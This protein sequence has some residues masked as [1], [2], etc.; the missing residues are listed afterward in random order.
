MIRRSTTITK[1]QMYRQQFS[2]VYFHS[3]IPA[4][5]P[6]TNN[7]FLVQ[8]M[9]TDGKRQEALLEYFKAPH[10]VTAAF[11]IHRLESLHTAVDVYR[12]AKV[13]NCSNLYIVVQLMLQYKQQKQNHNLIDDAV[14]EFNDCVAN[15]SNITAFTINGLLDEL[16][17]V[18]RIHEVLLVFR[19]AI[20]RNLHI[21]DYIVSVLLQCCKRI[22]RFD[23]SLEIWNSMNDTF[24]FRPNRFCYSEMI[25][26]YCALNNLEKAV[27]ILRD[28]RKNSIEATDF[29]FRYLIR[30]CAKTNQR[31]LL[32]QVVECLDASL[33]ETQQKVHSD[34]YCRN[35]LVNMYGDSEELD[36]AVCIFDTIPVEQRN[37][38]TWTT[39]MKGYI[40]NNDLS[41]AV[42][43]LDTMRNAGTKPNVVTYT[44]L[45]SGCVEASAL[46]I[47]VD[48]H[49]R[50]IQEGI[51]QNI[52][53]MSTLVNM[54]GSCGD[55]DEAIRVFDTIPFDHRNVVSWTSMIK[56][57]IS[58]NNF[59]AAVDLLDVMT[60]AGINPDAVTFAT[61]L[62][63][64]VEASS[65]SIGVKLHKKL[66]QED[67]EQD[68]VLMNALVN[69]YGNCGDI[70]EAVRVFDAISFE[71]RDAITWTFMIKAYLNNGNPN[72]AI[73]LLD[74]MM[75]AGVK[76]NIVT[77]ITL[78]TGCAD[79][80]MPDTG[81]ML[82]KRIVQED[83]H[84]NINLKGAL[85]NM[86]GK[87]SRIEDAEFAFSSVGIV[88]RT[89]E[90][91]GAM[92]QAYALNGMC[93]K[94]VYTFNNIPQKLQPNSVILISVL[95]ACS[96]SFMA[97]QALN[98]Y[99]SMESRWDVVP[100]P[101]HTV[102]LVDALARS[103]KLDEAEKVAL[104]K[105]P[106]NIVAWM[107][108]IGACRAYNDVERARRVYTILKSL[109][110][111]IASTHVLMSNILTTHG[112]MES[113]NAVR[114]E[115]KKDR[116]KTIPGLT[117]IQVN[118]K[119]HQFL[120]EDKNHPQIKQIYAYLE[121]LIGKIM[122]EG[123][124]PDPNWVTRDTEDLIER[125]RLICLH[126]EKIAL[127]YGLM[128]TPPDSIITISKNLRVCG[129]CHTATKFIAKV[130]NRYINVRDANRF[131]HFTP[132]GNCSCGDKW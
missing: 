125:K 5:A 71:K 70:L 45:L 28:M 128:E 22:K 117:N 21:S 90:T 109:D 67:I 81:I 15:N 113:R 102:C 18:D 82:H 59:D 6:S 63:G 88:D 38:V 39:M 17:R 129:D 130:T 54:Y 4:L 87:C 16:Q 121:G 85:I 48:L 44:T 119:V 36:K 127:A 105:I 104:E 122:E 57:Y 86:Y 53:L 66:V 50:L 131:H 92:I 96:H 34:I 97:E 12:A 19:Y 7:N 49:K 124:I 51:E 41:A 74:A 110:S 126:S 3:N 120:S 14:T 27:T 111:T 116:I 11:L 10:P 132:D 99:N 9:F 31:I 76:P 60:D 2:E 103:G 79:Y 61:L 29:A 47:G 108:I 64:C 23:L 98:I 68:T 89:I 8:S 95:T 13:H 75:H 94:A 24:G 65:L 73:G 26:M 84:Q 107:A 114:H 115:M 100:E 43:L 91:W 35:A 25:H 72:E 78:L 123:Y 40:S 20:K 93:E 46:D 42:S 118:G 37:V 112:D 1:S 69:M 62:S 83:I 101:A 30:E 106:D 56:A 80:C 58:N 52:F 55:I 77:Y 32:E 33:A